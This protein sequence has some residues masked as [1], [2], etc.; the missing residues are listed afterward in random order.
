MYVLGG[1]VFTCYFA[2]ERQ[3][4]MLLVDNKESVFM[5]VSVEKAW[6]MC[7]CMTISRYDRRCSINPPR[8]SGS[9]ETMAVMYRSTGRGG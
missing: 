2:I 6:C 7:C 4:S 1:V 9:P 3:I 5:S 8:P